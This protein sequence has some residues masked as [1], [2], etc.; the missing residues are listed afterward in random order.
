MVACARLT[1]RIPP[2]RRTGP[3]PAATARLRLRIPSR[4]GIP[5]LPL[6]PGGEQRRRKPELLLPEDEE[7]TRSEPR[8]EQA[9]LRAGREQ[10]QLFDLTSKRPGLKVAPVLVD[11]RGD[12]RPVVEPGAAEPLLVEGEPE[13]PDEVERR[14]RDGAGPRDVAGVRRDLRR[15]EDE[16][17]GRV[18]GGQGR[19]GRH[20]DREQPAVAAQPARSAHR[21]AGCARC[22][23]TT[24]RCSTPRRPTELARAVARFRAAE[25]DVL[26]VNGGDGTAH[27][28]LTAFVR[29]YGAAPLPRLLLLRGGSMNTVAHGHG[30]RGA[31]RADPARGALRRR[32][33]APLR[34][35]R[36]R[37]PRASP[38]TGPRPRTASSSG[39]ARSWRS[40]RRTTPPA[41]PRRRPLPRSSCAPSAPPLAAARS[42][43]RSRGASGC[44]SSPTATS[45]RTPV[46]GARRRRDPRHRLRVPGFRAVRRAARLVP[47]G[48]PHR[49][50]AAARARAAAH[51]PRALRGAAPLA[52]DEVARELV[53]EG[54]GIRFT[55]DG[56]LY[57][58]RAEVRLTTGPGVALVLP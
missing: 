3:T 14:T 23:A 54:D 39:P 53:A 12:L 10:V 20:R 49:R 8:L 46:P 7:V 48:G 34:T 44:G 58:A 37:P 56:D 4:M 52:Q 24:A 26:G 33:G 57:A 32:R 25:I 13:R 35:D 42:R 31:T 50:P 27:V 1:P 36:A 19:H 47:R 18:D 38:Q 43:R 15:H 45:G 40:S 9:P 29:A 17:E 11:L 55:V 30:I 5:H 22:S 21:R 6:R 2:A 41:A 16:L 51:P 28:V